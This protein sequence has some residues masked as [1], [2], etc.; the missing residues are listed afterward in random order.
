MNLLP[1]KTVDSVLSS[2]STAISQLGDVETQS[3]NEVLKQDEIIE[4]AAVNRKAAVGE[5]ERAQRVRSK[6]LELV[7]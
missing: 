7:A 6:L 3:N 5:L 2:I 1:R 4:L